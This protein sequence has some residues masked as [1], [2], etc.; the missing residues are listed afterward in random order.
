MA[1]PSRFRDYVEAM[2]KAS[3]LAQRDF[4]ELWD[5]IRNREPEEIRNLLLA[6]LPGIIY[7]YGDIAAVAAA[8]YYEGERSDL[9]SDDFTCRLSEGVPL[10]QIEAS[11]RYAAGHLFG[12]DDGVRPERHSSL[13]SG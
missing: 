4:S 8:D 10:E 11:V 2:D 5:R 9:R 13:F 12:G 1:S 6:L 3:L 7:K